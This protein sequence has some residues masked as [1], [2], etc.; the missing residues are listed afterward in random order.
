VIDV[1]FRQVKAPTLQI[2]EWALAKGQTVVASIGLLHADE[3]VCR[4][5]TGFDPDRFIARPP[6]PAQWIPYGGGVRRC[7]GAAFAN[8]EIRVVPRTLLRDCVIAPSSDREEGCRSRVGT[9][10]LATQTLE[11]TAEAA[12][13]R[14]GR[15]V[16]QR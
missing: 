6:D 12:P 5:A 16:S 15:E 7:I 8:V 1:T 3:A 9:G 2:G 14:G 13:R 11:L 4:N 10:A